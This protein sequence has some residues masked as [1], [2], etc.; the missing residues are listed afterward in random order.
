MS[1]NESTDKVNR[2]LGGETHV[3]MTTGVMAQWYSPCLEPWDLTKG[4]GFEPIGVQVKALSALWLQLGVPMACLL[5]L[6]LC[7]KKQRE[8][9]CARNNLGEKSVW[10]YP[11]P[12]S[13]SS[14]W[15]EQYLSP[16]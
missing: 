3:R 10:F 14:L 8:K 5:G 2:K 1:S 16:L 15:N 13:F 6:L 9:P 4:S 7:S 11:H 12:F